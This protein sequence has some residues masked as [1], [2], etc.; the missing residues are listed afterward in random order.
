LTYLIRYGAMGHVARFRAGPPE[1]PFHRGQAVVI[2]SHRGMELG[3]VLVRFDDV[4]LPKAL[5][6][7]ESPES[8]DSAGIESESEPRVL[9]AAGS[10]DLARAE[11][12]DAFQ[13]ARFARCQRI[14]QEE[15]WPWELLDVEPLLDG[16]TTVLH[17]LGPRQ[18]DERA[19]R[20]RFRAAC[21][22]D[23]VF[24]PIG[25]EPEG[26]ESEDLDGDHGCGSGC[27]SGG[28]ES[29]GGCGRVATADTGLTTASSAP[30]TG[31][32]AHRSHGSCDSCGISR[33][34]AGRR[35]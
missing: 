5:G 31:E 35:R 29:G 12:A 21:E 8:D 13:P 6:G 23:V 4:S 14:L 3:E 32:V 16:Q 30:A 28:C 18:I 7:F 19:L 34:L 2:Q 10:E 24:E 25:S 27:S 11:E 22:F 20:A 9:R 17:Y 15:G 1:G 33:L 26:S